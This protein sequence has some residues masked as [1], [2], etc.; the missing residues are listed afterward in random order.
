MKS[1]TVITVTF[2]VVSILLIMIFAKKRDSEL[3]KY[4]QLSKIN[5]K[6]I[7]IDA[8]SQ[9]VTFKVDTDVRLF[10]FSPYKIE[11]LDNK[12]IFFENKAKIGD[13]ILK[14]E[15]SNFVILKTQDQEYSFNF[16]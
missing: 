15:N 12:I 8:T 2:G 10:K 3:R 1:Y 6:I 16:K 9:G 7:E 13:S 14:K 5:G 4:F 11:T